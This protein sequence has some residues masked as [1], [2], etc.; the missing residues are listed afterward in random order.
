[1]PPPVTR[2]PRIKV[3]D[4]GSRPSHHDE[5]GLARG[6]PVVEVVQAVRVAHLVQEDVDVLRVEVVE[7]VV[8][9]QLL[10]PV[11][12]EAAHLPVHAL[13]E[14]QR[15]VVAALLALGA[16]AEV[17]VR[18][19]E[20]AAALR[21][22][23]GDAVDIGRVG[24]DVQAR[25]VALEERGVVGRPAGDGHVDRL[26]GEAVEAGQGLGHPLVVLGAQNRLELLALRGGDGA[27]ARVPADAVLD[28]GLG[29]HDV[30]I[31]K[32]LE[33][34]VVRG[35][36]VPDLCEALDEVRRRI[37]Y[38]SLAH[39]P[40]CNRQLRYEELTCRAGSR[41]GAG[42]CDTTRRGGSRTT[43]RGG[44]R[45]TS[46]NTS[47][48]RTS[49]RRTSARGSTRL[50][51]T[52]VSPPATVATTVAPALRSPLRLL[53]RGGGAAKAASLVELV[54]GARVRRTNGLLNSTLL[55]GVR[56]GQGRKE[57]EHSDSLHD[58][59]SRDRCCW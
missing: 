2:H 48:R 32:V 54:G 58:F 35:V 15:D 49:T 59:G 20:G 45:S 17:V 14:P 40:K 37:P 46:G 4:F 51:T 12:A 55:S 21:V 42:S 18:V 8:D 11:A 31:A 30:V 1:M 13:A 36:L 6:L 43:R 9:G 34:G 19:V 10:A 38:G 28:L 44:S 29:G 56:L 26:V 50:L 16:P 53:P 5:G 27:A 25:G 33:L 41:R 47:T 24:V 23:L 22:A 7:H 3:S 39:C 57:G 52:G